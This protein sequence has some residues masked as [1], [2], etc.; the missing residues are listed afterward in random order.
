MLLFQKFFQAFHKTV[1][2]I[3]H[4]I[5][6]KTR[7]LY[8]CVCGCFGTAPSPTASPCA[9][10]SPSSHHSQ[11]M[12]VGLRFW[13]RIMRRMHSFF[14]REFSGD[15][16]ET[17]QQ[18]MDSHS[19]QRPR[20][21]HLRHRRSN[22]DINRNAYR[23][24]TSLDEATTSGGSSA[25]LLP[26]PLPPSV[27]A[28]H[29]TVQRVLP[30]PDYDCLLEVICSSHS[31]QPFSSS[32][33][34]LLEDLPNMDLGVLA[35]SIVNILVDS[36]DLR[37]LLIALYRKDIARC[38]D[39][40]T[41]FRSQTLATRMFCEFLFL[42]G[43]SY[44]LI[45]LKPVIDKICKEKKCCEIDPNRLTKGE[46]IDKNRTNLLQ[47]FELCFDRITSSSHRCPTEIRSALADL[48]N[49]VQTQTNRSDMQYFSLSSFLIMRFF[50]AA[51]LNPK[52]F[53]LVR[54]H[55]VDSRSARTLLLLSKLLQRVANCTVSNHPL[56][57]K[58][59]WLTSVLE[60][61]TDESHLRLMAK[62]LDDVSSLP[63]QEEPLSTPLKDGDLLHYSRICPQWK[64]VLQQKR[65]HVL[66]TEEELIWHKKSDDVTAVSKQQSIP[67]MEI[68]EIRIEGK[69]LL[70]RKADGSE[71]AFQTESQTET[72]EWKYAIE[73]QIARGKCG[74][75][76]R[77]RQLE[78]IHLLMLQ[79]SEGI[80]ELKKNIESGN[81]SE[82][83]PEEAERRC[84]LLQTVNH[85]LHITR[86]IEAL[87]QQYEHDCSPQRDEC[88]SSEMDYL[89]SNKPNQ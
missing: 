44:L 65:R 54:L 43:H 41:L 57:N 18:W 39:H 73:R 4:I 10:P 79:Q 48:R 56:S 33:V 89:L 74:K 31:V 50:A 61:I 55:L 6:D 5:S 46:S 30:L 67:L 88:E 64:K 2:F 85:A 29:P 20:L 11:Q 47:Y 69:N 36:E 71:V 25:A 21:P 66:L 76:D 84:S 80:V 23:L 27:S 32:L 52:P 63:S 17:R 59:P 86:Q 28:L 9:L 82:L 70:I 34:S 83:H 14:H 40:N 12:A 49:V 81:I 3:W 60:L 35:Q 1:F 77:G 22:S 87:H 37:C 19:R 16:A 26:L 45:T 62:F 38:Q 51:L 72:E 13:Q 58:E 7:V 24:V 42:H 78:S 68:S 15:S 8:D 75:I 53:G